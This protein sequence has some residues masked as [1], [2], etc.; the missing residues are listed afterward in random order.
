[1]TSQEPKGTHM[2]ILTHE[3]G[4]ATLIKQY[5]HDDTKETVWDVLADSGERFHLSQRY[6]ETLPRLEYVQVA[7]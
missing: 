7:A 5:R 3:F 2:K 4:P 1:M 6:V